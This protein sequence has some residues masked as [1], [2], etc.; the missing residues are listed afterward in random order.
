[1]QGKGF[2]MHLS[3][4]ESGVLVPCLFKVLFRA[5]SAY[6]QQIM[7]RADYVCLSVQSSLRPHVV[8]YELFRKI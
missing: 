8:F 4:M 1:M 3:L 2:M 6:N 7:S 5:E